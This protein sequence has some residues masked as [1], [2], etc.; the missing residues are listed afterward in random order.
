MNDD[1]TPLLSDRGRVEA[2]QCP[3]I[4]QRIAS[5]TASVEDVE[6]WYLTHDPIAEE[7]EEKEVRLIAM[8]GSGFDE[9]H[10][11][12]LQK[13]SERAALYESAAFTLLVSIAE[14]KLMEEHP[15]D[16]DVQLRSRFKH[17]PLFAGPEYITPHLMNEIP[18]QLSEEQLYDLY[19]AIDCMHLCSSLFV[20]QANR[21]SSMIEAGNKVPETAIHQK[22]CQDKADVYFPK[23][24]ELAMELARRG[25]ASSTPESKKMAFKAAMFG[26]AAILERSAAINRFQQ[27]DESKAK[28][29]EGMHLV[30]KNYAV[31]IKEYFLGEAGVPA[32]P[33]KGERKGD[34]HEALYLLDM[35]FLLSQ[36]QDIAPNWVAKPVFP[37]MDRP[38]I[39]APRANRGVDVTIN[40][41][42]RNLHIQLKSSKTNIDKQYH[43]RILVK[44][45]S[46]FQDVDVRRL[47]A[48]L[49][50]YEAWVQDG[51][52]SERAA[53]IYRYIL[54]TATET[55]QDIVEAQNLPQS[56]FL[57]QSLHTAAFSRA[58][59][60][61]I[62]RRLGEFSGRKNKT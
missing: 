33:F 10:L 41:G 54:P 55:L 23:S 31:L 32:K 3:E 44:H 6:A 11:E 19:I 13:K 29:E 60:R 12:E 43:P 38:E 21:L 24:M 39:G 5:Y 51:Y 1:P 61:R 59:R 22:Q 50:A 15:N 16:W 18:A 57:I 27:S 56:E 47:G 20:N 46:N 14:P 62:A 2:A 45:E 37:R 26:F 42:S 25:D 8:G 35:S 40:N 53:R 30:V 49:N 34:L 58:E 4:E 52:S 48:K 28:F 9:A 17:M 36:N 7:L